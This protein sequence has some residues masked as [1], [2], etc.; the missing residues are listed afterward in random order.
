MKGNEHRERGVQEAVTT[1]ANC[2]RPFPDS[3][4]GDVRDLYS[5]EGQGKVE[6]P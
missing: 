6:N 2:F 3:L 5:R 1:L 4:L